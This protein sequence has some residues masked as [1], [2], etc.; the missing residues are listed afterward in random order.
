MKV[1]VLTFFRNA[2]YGAMLQARALC[3]FLESSGFDVV[4][5]DTVVQTL[6]RRGLLG[7]CARSALGLMAGDR[8][9]MRGTFRSFLRARAESSIESYADSFPVSPPL[10]SEGA[11]RAYAKGLDAVVVG[12]DQMWNPHWAL[13]YL[14]IVFLGFAPPGCRRIAYA[15]SFGVSEWGND[16]REDAASFL[17]QFHAISVRETGGE[18][19]V[20]ALF[21]EASVQTVL[22]PTLLIGSA[23]WRKQLPEE[24]TS[25]AGRY[26]FSYFL[27]WT[28]RLE[29]VQWNDR[30]SA[31][32]A[33]EEVLGVSA[34]VRGRILRH[35]CS[36]NGVSGK[37]DVS[38]WLVRIAN[39]RF[40]ITNS[41]HGTVFSILFHRPFAVVLLDRSKAASDMNGRIYSLLDMLGLS[42]RMLP[43]S[44]FD[45]LADVRSHPID[46]DAVESRL[47][48]E[49]KR[50]A[51]FLLDALS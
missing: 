37:I 7:T 2:N 19:I 9:R 5:L 10:R 25:N 4:F 40:V 3:S 11:L 38:E 12:S 34:P 17:R 49:R 51:A 14:P 33:G 45:A 24:S 6:H 21:P 27:R 30:L 23:F 46:W 47:D 48:L 44:A 18:G 15:P 36:R 31:L 50:S 28:R 39:A 16:R 32:S 1:G 42:D 8:K 43:A 26:S 41:F 20:R 13:P 29:A 22:D 35:L